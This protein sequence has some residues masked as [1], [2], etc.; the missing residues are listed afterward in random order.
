MHPRGQGLALMAPL[1]VLPQA[2]IDE[3]MAGAMAGK[4]LQMQ[5]V[6]SN[7]SASSAEKAVTI[8]RLLRA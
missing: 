5:S 6:H 8:Y 4:G 7:V 2:A 3:A 1:L